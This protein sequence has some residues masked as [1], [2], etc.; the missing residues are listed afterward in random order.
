MSHITP[1]TNIPY[2]KFV[3]ETAI[4]RSEKASNAISKV[5]KAMQLGH[6]QRVIP[7][8]TAALSSD[9]SKTIGTSLFIV[10][11]ILGSLI[12]GLNLL[13][14]TRFIDGLNC[15]KNNR[16][17]SKK[18]KKAFIKLI[19]KPGNLEKILSPEFC[20]K[21]NIHVGLFITAK[22]GLKPIC[23]KTLHLMME[24][25]K[26]KRVMDGIGLI[27]S[28]LSLTIFLASMATPVP[29]WIV[30]FLPTLFFITT[31]V[32]E[33]QFI[34][35][36]SLSLTHFMPDF[37]KN[38][39]NAQQLLEIKDLSAYFEKNRA[40]FGLYLTDEESKQLDEKMAQIRNDQI[41]YQRYQSLEA[42]K[43]EFSE[44][45]RKILRARVTKDKIE[46]GGLGFLAL[47][48]A[49]ALLPSPALLAVIVPLI[50]IGL[51]LKFKSS[52]FQ[53]ARVGTQPESQ[54]S[55]SEKKATQ[56]ATTSLL[57]AVPGAF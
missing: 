11:S 35:N 28:I 10:G 53:S 27:L 20:K 42:A 45:L 31:Y 4:D 51:V 3:S 13:Q 32:I 17:P 12:Y 37:I 49:L 8:V 33:K 41:D 57:N 50:T 48:G 23:K 22:G 19:T 16:F 9:V 15:L 43:E 54:A 38:M 39:N 6:V 24:Q 7:A 47:G 34:D 18:H 44:H 36:A 1:T 40:R 46:M 29:V 56:A 26:L 30:H 14:K 52:W 21:Y 25:A 2:N 5:S 55:L